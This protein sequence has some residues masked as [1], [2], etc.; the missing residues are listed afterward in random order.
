MKD[1]CRDRCG[2]G[3]EVRKE[4]WDRSLVDQKR[5]QSDESSFHGDPL[6]PSSPMTLDTKVEK[7]GVYIPENRFGDT[8]TNKSRWLEFNC[9]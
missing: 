8:T 3:P 1:L 6:A 4:V 2:D 7:E 9:Q 5:S